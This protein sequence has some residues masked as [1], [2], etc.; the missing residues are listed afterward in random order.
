[1]FVNNSISQELIKETFRKNPECQ[2]ILRNVN[3]RY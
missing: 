3:I 1:M 2:G